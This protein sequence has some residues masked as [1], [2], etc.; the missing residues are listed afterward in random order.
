MRSVQG[1]LTKR[2]TGGT[3][4]ALL[5]VPLTAA[6]TGTAAAA[7]AAPSAP[8]A[9]SASRADERGSGALGSNS[10][11]IVLDS[12]GSMA[13]KDDSGKSR[14]QSA[15][16]AVGT[17]VDSLPDRYPTG[18]RVY[19]AD[20]ADSCTDT[21]LAEPVR[22]L[23]AGSIKRAVAKVEPKGE[24]PIGYS[25][26]KAAADLSR[27]PEHSLGRRTIV[28]VSDGEDTCGTPKPCEVAKELSRD[29]LDLRIDAIG[30]QVKG[31]ARKQ[32]ECIAEA[33]HGK[34][35]DA[36]KA[37]DLARELER[38]GRQSAD[39]Y[40]LKGKRVTGTRSSADAPA[41]RAPGQYLD[42]IG[43]GETRWYSTELDARAAA[44]AVDFAATGVPQPGAR[45]S[46]L[47]SLKLTMRS[48]DGSMCGDD[49]AMFGQNEGG[50]PL[51]T[52]VSRIP[53]EDG[54]RE[55][56]KPGRYTFEL[57]RDTDKDSDQARWPVELR[58]GTER[59]LPG[60]AVPARA[61]TGY[62]NAGKDATLPTGT[63]KDIEG[64]TGFNDARQLKKGVWRDTLLPAET[65]WYR[66]PVGWNQQLRYDVEFANEPKR[67][68]IAPSTSYVWTQ[69][70]APGRLPVPDGLE[71]SPRRPY[72]GDPVK[73]SQGTVPVAWKNRAEPRSSVRPVRRGGDF[74]IAVTLGAGA[75][76]IADNAAVRVVLRVDVKGKA[77]Q[78]P[79]HDAPFVDAKGVGAPPGR[80]LGEAAGGESARSGGAGG[81]AK[82]GSGL[83]PLVPAGGGAAAVLLV[84]GGVW[85]ALRRRARVRSM[86]GMR[87]GTW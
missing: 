7:P 37:D 16:N 9:A 57:S 74:Y 75:A 39:G 2:V 43:P 30:F 77:K 44:K 69:M 40:R 14:M 12:S 61:E 86:N 36:P 15:R 22:A 71:F 29:G 5:S 35:Y 85:Y 6:T 23:E 46:S 64:G 28:L 20:K 73:V 83:S 41:L 47:D 32:L 68:E 18:L 49:R 1:R 26:K 38:A 11:E 67:R 33:G 84:S 27:G 70:Y 79:E 52:A 72:L 80:R 58:L 62:R 63:P 42:T 10:M 50:T 87:G 13:E 17:L 45:V 81:E 65:R 56:D 21:R 48:S 34:Y 51:T 25:L 78:G 60:G 4:L 54:T 3:L 59:A 55:C 24:T 31:K 8:A 76:R 53:S 66:V 82:G 19:G